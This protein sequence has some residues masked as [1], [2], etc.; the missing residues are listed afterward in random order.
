MEV[1]SGTDARIPRTASVPAQHRDGP[2]NPS[3]PS[4]PASS[5][6]LCRMFHHLQGF[7][8]FVP[9][10]L[11]DAL[12]CLCEIG[13]QSYASGFRSSSFV[14][15]TAPQRALVLVVRQ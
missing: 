10:L 15:M 14:P 11:Q 3:A 8:S 5:D 7:L 9:D 1:L 4:D 13:R 2:A 6:Q 12:E